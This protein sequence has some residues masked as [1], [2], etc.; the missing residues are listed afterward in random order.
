MDTLDNLTYIQYDGITPEHHHFKSILEWLL[1]I[2]CYRCKCIIDKT[3][4]NQRAT[5]NLPFNESRK[6]KQEQKHIT[7]IQPCPVHQARWKD[8]L[9]KK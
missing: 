6:I 1:D 4:Y 8:H 7:S 9:D 3:T 2:R 5:Y